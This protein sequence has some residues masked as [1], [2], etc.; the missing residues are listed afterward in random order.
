MARG[1]KEEI[2]CF[3]AGCLSIIT[4]PKLWT[5]INTTIFCRLLGIIM[6]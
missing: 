1:E 5:F 3:L 6:L 2:H 4:F